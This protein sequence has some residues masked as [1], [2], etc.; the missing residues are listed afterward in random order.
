M[1]LL[2]KDFSVRYS[3]VELDEFRLHIEQKIA[4]AQS[5]LDSTNKQIKDINENGFNQQG[6]DWYDDTSNHTDMEM[7]DRMAVRQ[8]DLMKHLKNALLRVQNKTYGICFVTGKLIEKRRL[9]LVPHTTKSVEGKSIKTSGGSAPMSVGP[10]L[11]HNTRLSNEE[12]P[13]E[14]RQMRP[15]SN[16][17][18]GSV[19]KDTSDW[20]GPSGEAMEDAGYQ[21]KFDDED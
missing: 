14:P 1:D 18:G 7:L 2:M 4:E 9:L 17:S 15:I 3:D 11:D 12:A 19:G 21:R 20:N 8:I 10:G 6:G 16:R 13:K 5:E